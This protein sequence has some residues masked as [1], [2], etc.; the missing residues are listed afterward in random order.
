LKDLSASD[1]MNIANLAMLE[2]SESEVESLRHDLNGI[3][4]AFEA[5]DRIV[6]DNDVAYDQRSGMVLSEVS[7][8]GEAFSRMRTDS[9]GQRTV[10]LAVLSANFPEREGSLMV[11]PQV[12]D[13][14]E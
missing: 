4:H 1:V 12:V 13:R 8:Q 3:L 9:V 11:V 2:V 10:D 14:D 5:L 6:I 7:S